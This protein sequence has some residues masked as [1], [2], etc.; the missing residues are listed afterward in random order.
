[1]Y[2]DV[3]LDVETDRNG[4]LTVIGLYHKQAGIVQLVGDEI[5]RKNLL[6]ALP[7]SG[8]LFTYNGH[9]F[10]LRC[11]RCQLG[12]NLREMF[13]SVDLR[14]ICHE[15]GLTG[16]LKAVERA[17]GIRRELPDMDGYRAMVLWEE[18]R[19][20]DLEALWKLL[21][22]NREDVMNLIPIKEHLGL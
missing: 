1:M 16:G 10:D 7:A 5:S 13:H 20:G 9:C 15:R 14:W 22:Y 12:L 2:G 3:Y 8:R 17:L 6:S 4:R 21:L 18:Y 11:I 19:R